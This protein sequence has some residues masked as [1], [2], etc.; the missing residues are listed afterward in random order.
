MS[1]LISIVEKFPMR[2][3]TYFDLELPLLRQI[4]KLEAVDSKPYVWVLYQRDN[5]VHW[6]VETTHIVM[7]CEGQ[8]LS[9]DITEL[10]Y[11]GSLTFN[12]EDYQTQSCHYFTFRKEGIL[13]GHRQGDI[14][15]SKEH[16]SRVA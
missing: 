1:K 15:S 5:G 8:K 6:G 14:R 4:L 16:R 3:E 10:D 2:R 11:W 12:E 13:H 9:T 7:L